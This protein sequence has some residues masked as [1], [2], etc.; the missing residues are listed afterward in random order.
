M[1]PKF[2]TL[3]LAGMSSEDEIVVRTDLIVYILPMGSM[4]SRV[5]MK[6]AVEGFAV[7]GTPRDILKLIQSP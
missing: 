6:R 4:C 7:L 1:E 5:F 3:H 2:I